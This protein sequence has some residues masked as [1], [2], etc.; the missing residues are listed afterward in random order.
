MAIRVGLDQTATA[1]GSV[2]NNL[3]FGLGFKNKGFSIDYGYHPYVEAASDSTHYISITYLP[4]IVIKKEEEK[5]LKSLTTPNVIKDKVI[6]VVT[7]E[8]TAVPV[9]NKKKKLVKLSTTKTKSITVEA[10]LKKI[11][12]K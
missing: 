7:I 9:V 11:K 10:V 5:K 1:N 2:W 6:K 4:D 12:K 3:T 8:G